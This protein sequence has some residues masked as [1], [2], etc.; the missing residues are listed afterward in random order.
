MRWNLAVRD[1]LCCLPLLP[2]WEWAL[3]N[4]V[5]LN[6]NCKSLFVLITNIILVS[7]TQQEDLCEGNPCGKYAV[8]ESFSSGRFLC[9]CDRN[10]K[11]PV[12]NPYLECHQCS[13]NLGLAGHSSGLELTSKLVPELSP[14]WC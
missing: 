14:V 7:N 12:G 4:T 10:G 6:M 1:L 13:S 5:R 3:S 9:K 2:S 8:C 11:H